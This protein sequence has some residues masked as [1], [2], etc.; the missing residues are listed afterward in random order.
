MN[1]DMAR[2][3]ASSNLAATYPRRVAWEPS[4]SNFAFC[5]TVDPMDVVQ[6]LDN[7][8]PIGKSLSTWTFSV[9][10]EPTTFEAVFFRRGMSSVID[11]WGLV[12]RLMLMPLGI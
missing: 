9:L 6:V 12:Q 7:L 11:I 8:H 2:N 3:A 5:G 4:A 1:I 10:L